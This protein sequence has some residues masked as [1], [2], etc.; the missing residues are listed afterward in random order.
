MTSRPWRIATALIVSLG[1]LVLIAAGA[2]GLFVEGMV[3]ATLIRQAVAGV[4]S[5]AHRAAG[6]LTLEQ[7]VSTTRSLSE[8]LAVLATGATYVMVTGPG[9]GF[10][11]SKGTPPPTAPAGGWANVP[12]EGWF[13]YAGVPYAY[14]RAPLE[15]SGAT[16]QLFVVRQ[17]GG[18]AA[19][20]GSLSKIL[21]FGWLLLMG[22]LLVGI[23][24]V[25]REITQPLDRLRAFATKVA[26]DPSQIGE[27]LAAMDGLAEVE[28]L[29]RAVN[30][31]L[32]RLEA[33]QRREQQ[34]ASD[35]AHALRTPVQVITGYLDTLR[36]WGQRDPAVRRQAMVALS[37]EASGMEVLI[38]RLLTLSQVSGERAN[39]NQRVDVGDLLTHILPD[40]QDVCARHPLIV[41]APPELIAM[42]DSALLSAV[43]RILVENADAYADPGGTVSVTARQEAVSVSVT[44][45][46]PG[47]PIPDDVLPH[48]FERFARGRQEANS[49]HFGLGLAI[50]DLMVGQM[51]ANWRVV[52]ADGVVSFTVLL[53]S[54]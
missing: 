42:A 43:L 47:P 25:V 31:M 3:R 48:L 35:A 46:N 15:V 19:L 1:A 22:T 41:D 20:V 50:A 49:S 34:F 33:A 29:S 26:A 45:S 7:K 53:A 54:T 8:D 36:R 38:Q 44:V 6:Q 39:S 37:R 40:L 2:A 21:V 52:S 28:E 13:H 12:P 30:R 17:E 14:A 24:I 27:R 4:A 23:L 5:T 10:E 9:G 51:N 18:E 32:A 16:W 11:L